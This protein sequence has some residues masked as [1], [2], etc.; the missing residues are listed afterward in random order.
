MTQLEDRVAR[1]EANQERMVSALELV[2][3]TQRE[4][5]AR[6]D[7]FAATQQAMLEILTEQGAILGQVVETQGSILRTLDGVVR[8]LDGVLET[9]GG[10]LK[11]QDGILQTQERILNKLI[12]HDAEFTLLK[13]YLRR[14]ET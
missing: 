13:N 14:D 11:T 2:V 4:M 9:Q 5:V 10:I 7:T 12:E 1:L 3:E 8:T 6:M